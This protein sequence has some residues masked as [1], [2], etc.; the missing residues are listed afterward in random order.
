[1]ISL[2]VE[3]SLPVPLP[4]ISP[5]HHMAKGGGDAQQHMAQALQQR[6]SPTEE[7]PE[8]SFRANS[9]EIT[10]HGV[11]SIECSFHVEAAKEVSGILLV[12]IEGDAGDVLAVFWLLKS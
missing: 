11:E 2:G 7:L 10:A 12:H 3:V 9:L 6:G 5:L 1:M 4:S 8:Y